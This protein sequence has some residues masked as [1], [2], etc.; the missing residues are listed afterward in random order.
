MDAMIS[1]TNSKDNV[2]EYSSAFS[3]LFSTKQYA[4]NA[5]NEVYKVNPDEHIDNRDMYSVGKKSVTSFQYQHPQLH[6]YFSE[7]AHA[8]LVDLRS[9]VKGE[10]FYVTLP[11][12]TTKFSGTKRSTTD[13]IAQLLDVY[14]ATYKDIEKAHKHH[15]G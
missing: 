1:M 5:N 11:D 10:R 13:D 2:S 12:G 9:S 6:N 15:G 3:E 14:K 8:M 4:V 7:Y